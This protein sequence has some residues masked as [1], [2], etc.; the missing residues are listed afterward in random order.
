[1]GPWSPWTRCA[2]YLPYARSARTASDAIRK[3]R[4][5]LTK[6]GRRPVRYDT[7]VNSIKITRSDP[8]Q[9][10]ILTGEIFKPGSASSAHNHSQNWSADDWS[11]TN[12]DRQRQSTVQRA[13]ATKELIKR[14]LQHVHAACVNWSCYNTWVISTAMFGRWIRRRRRQSAV[15]QRHFT[16]GLWK[17]PIF[18]PQMRSHSS[19]CPQLIVNSADIFIETS[20]HEL[21]TWSHELICRMKAL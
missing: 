15:R 13:T 12:G 11:W 14:S 18:V 16:A 17:P 8:P 4:G 9:S 5:F 7:G 6:V 1:M 19:N 3:R 2:R 21:R 20:L 10:R